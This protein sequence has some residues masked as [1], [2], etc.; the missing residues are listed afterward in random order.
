MNAVYTG[1]IHKF[2]DE[3]MTNHYRSLKED[4][5]ENWGRAVA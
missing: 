3:F 4:A 2:T 5:F 1:K